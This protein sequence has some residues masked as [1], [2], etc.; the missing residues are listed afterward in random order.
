MPP[1]RLGAVTAL[2]DLGPEV[3]KSYLPDIVARTRRRPRIVGVSRCSGPFSMLLE[4][5]CSHFFVG[6]EE[7]SC[8]A[9]FLPHNMRCGPKRSSRGLR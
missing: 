8:H 5:F 1:C 2:G 9:M 7:R 4:R 6:F 3:V